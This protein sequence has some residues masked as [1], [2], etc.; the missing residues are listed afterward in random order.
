[1]SAGGITIEDRP[2]TT[3]E[4]AAYLGV[5]P[6]SIERWRLQRVGPPFIKLSARA[7]RYSSAALR[8]WRDRQSV[9]CE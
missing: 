6:R 5:S 7:I 9:A 1:M 4:V 2:M 8:E 3:D